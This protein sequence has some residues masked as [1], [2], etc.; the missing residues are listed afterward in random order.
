MATPYL[1]MKYVAA[2][3][4]SVSR[5]ASGLIVNRCARRVNTA[6]KQ[7]QPGQQIRRQRGVIQRLALLEP[8]RQPVDSDGVTGDEQQQTGRRRRTRYERC[9]SE[10]AIAASRNYSPV[11]RRPSS[12]PFA[13]QVRTIGD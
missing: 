11:V 7:A 1:E 9:E 6:M 5:M 12:V 13:R 3:L 2:A 4:V 10:A 8:F